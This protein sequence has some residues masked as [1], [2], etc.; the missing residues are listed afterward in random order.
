MENEREKTRMTTSIS[1]IS[2]SKSCLR[3]MENKSKKIANKQI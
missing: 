2:L 1:S 3:Y